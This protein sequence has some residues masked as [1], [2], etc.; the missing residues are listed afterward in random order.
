M[1]TSEHQLS[2][3][4]QQLSLRKDELTSSINHSLADLEKQLFENVQNLIAE[5]QVYVQDVVADDF[6]NLHQID[7]D[8][9]SIQHLSSQILRMQDVLC[10][11]T[12]LSKNIIH[13]GMDQL[14]QKTHQDI[15]DASDAEVDSERDGN[16]SASG[17]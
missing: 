7:H 8:L 1:N 9:D 2:E 17:L 4:Y 6:F 13:R 5:L 14:S 10:G 11:F 15:M 12:D 3:D 16:F